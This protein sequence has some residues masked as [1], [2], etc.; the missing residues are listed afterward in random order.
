[1]HKL[2]F[3]I[4]RWRDFKNA[5]EVYCNDDIN[6]LESHLRNEI[7]TLDGCPLDDEE[8]VKI[9]VHRLGDGDALSKE[10][11][12]VNQGKIWKKR[13]FWMLS[14]HILVSAIG[15]LLSMLAALFSLFNV[16]DHLSLKFINQDLF[17]SGEMA[18]VLIAVS[19]FMFLVY[20]QKVKMSGFSRFFLGLH[21]L[22][23][24]LM[25]VPLV[26]WQLFGQQL[27][28]IVMTRSF[29]PEQ[30]GVLAMQSALWRGLWTILVAIFFMLCA[31]SV[32]RQRR[33][34]QLIKN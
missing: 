33:T 12:K 31:V 3:F 14:G 13:L 8:K 34:G 4:E 29:S 16:T 25:L 20:R 5:Q 23:L 6:E 26:L 18:L 27:L 21:P 17:V 22:F 30:F 10:F 11:A 19:I 24:G 15:V 32:I 28:Y 9:A 2:E 1:M 7:E